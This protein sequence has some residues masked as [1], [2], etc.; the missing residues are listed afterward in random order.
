MGC[1]P[2]DGWVMT[3]S[4]VLFSWLVKTAK[5]N[6]CPSLTG[7]CSFQRAFAQPTNLRRRTELEPKITF[8]TW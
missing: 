5:E 2:T 6:S 4:A 7:R 1:F 3:L 8:Y